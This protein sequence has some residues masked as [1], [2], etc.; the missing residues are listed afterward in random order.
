MTNSDEEL[1]SISFGP[2][3]DEKENKKVIDV[4][5]GIEEF[6]HDII[7][8]HINSDRVLNSVANDYMIFFDDGSHI[9]WPEHKKI[10][11]YDENSESENTSIQKDISDLKVGDQIIISKRS[12]ELRKVIDET[13]SENESFS[14][15][16]KTDHDWR[17]KILAH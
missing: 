17:D 5:P 11:C 4:I 10:F 15:S 3:K 14:K 12:R 6:V 8:V 2:C 13:L 7:K 9:D 16:I 1:I